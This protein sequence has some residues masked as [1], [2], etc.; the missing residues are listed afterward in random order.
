MT[1]YDTKN[2]SLVKVDGTSLPYCSEYSGSLSDVDYDSGRTVNGGKMTRNRLRN[3]V[4][5]LE[6]AYDLLTTSQAS[7]ILKLIKSEFFSVEFYAIDKNERITRQMYVGDKSFE[8]GMAVP[9][10]K[11]SYEMCVMNLKFNFI[12][13]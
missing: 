2:V 7:K 6:F 8:W 3:D 11:T 12:E 9:K 1:N 10:G 5:K 13:K 4:Y